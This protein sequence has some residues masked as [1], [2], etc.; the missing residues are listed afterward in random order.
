MK[1]DVLIIHLGYFKEIVTKRFLQ[2]YG[3]EEE[4]FEE[5]LET[6]ERLEPKKTVFTHI[7]EAWGRSYENYKQIENQLEKF[8]IQFAYD[9]MV[10][11]I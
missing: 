11:K 3:G 9:G 1:P 6:I 8:N 7:E 10:I 2:Q 4:S 5:N